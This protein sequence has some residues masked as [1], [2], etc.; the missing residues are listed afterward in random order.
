[1]I[2]PISQSVVSRG[3]APDHK[4][5]HEYGTKNPDCLATG[6]ECVQQAVLIIEYWYKRRASISPAC[7]LCPLTIDPHSPPTECVLSAITGIDNFFDEG[8]GVWRPRW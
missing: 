7:C 3:K 1:M 2:R 6:I 5:K 8:E 4:H